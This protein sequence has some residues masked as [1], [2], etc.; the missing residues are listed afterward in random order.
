MK[1]LAVLMLL[2]VSVALAGCQ[3][4]PWQKKSSPPVEGG[5]ASYES[6]APTEQGLALAPDQRFADIPL[7]V[8]VKEDLEKSFVYESS[9]LQVGRMVYMTKSSVTELTSFFIREC[10]T[11]GWTLRSVTQ[12]GGADLL[13][14]KTGK[15]LTVN[16]RDLGITKGRQLVVTMV[17]DQ[18]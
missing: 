16:V 6:P 5:D 1:N 10:P 11:A 14:T 3:S 13:F 7:P 4:M 12:A 2:A 17:P 8:G 9:S 15:K 18:G